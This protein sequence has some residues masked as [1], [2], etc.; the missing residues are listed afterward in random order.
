MSNLPIPPQHVP[1]PESRGQRQQRLPVPPIPPRNPP[2]ERPAGQVYDRAPYHGQDPLAGTEQVRPAPEQ[3]NF[4]ALC[5]ARGFDRHIPGF[6]C[7]N[8]PSGATIPSV[9][10]PAVPNPTTIPRNTG[11]SA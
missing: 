6:G 7:T 1:P 5:Q 8:V 3:P 9:P 2:T 11:R 4:E 10:M